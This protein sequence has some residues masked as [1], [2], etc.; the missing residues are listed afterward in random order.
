MN[1]V[2]GLTSSKVSLQRHYLSFLLTSTIPAI[3]DRTGVWAPR[4]GNGIT[5]AGASYSLSMLG[6][7]HSSS[8]L[9]SE[10]WTSWTSAYKPI[11]VSAD[12]GFPVNATGFT[13]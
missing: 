5:G 12:A 4:I 3:E 6:V 8:S 1:I 7:F 13:V 11:S 10:S 9:W 2:S